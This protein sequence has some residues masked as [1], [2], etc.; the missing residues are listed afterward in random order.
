MVTGDDNSNLYSL[1]IETTGLSAHADEITVMAITNGTESRIFRGSSA[2]ADLDTFIQERPNLKLT[3]HNLKFDLRFLI[4]KKPELSYLVDRWQHDSSLL[5]FTHQDKIPEGWLAA[6]EVNR[7]ILNKHRRGNPHRK[8]GPHSLKTTAP[9]YLG[10]EAFW[11]AENHDDDAYVMKDAEY[12]LQLTRYFLEKLPAASVDFYT[13]FYMPWTKNLLA[14]EMTGI[15]LDVAKLA[16]MTVDYET[17]RA[18][19]E[20]ELEELW[21]PHFKAW[22]ELKRAE[23]RERYAEMCA[24]ACSRP[25]ANVDKTQARYSELEA[26]ALSKLEPLNLASTQQL[27]WLLRAR[28]GLNPIDL[29]GNPSTD[30]EALE[31]LGESSPDVK[32]LIEMRQVTKIATAFLP[33][34]ASVHVN[35][36]IHCT[37]NVT[38][39]RTGRLSCSDVNLQQVPGEMH[40]LFVADEGKKLIVF[41]LAAIEPTVLAYYSEDPQLCELML[42]MGDFHSTNAKAMFGLECAVSEVKK[43]Y[44]KYRG[45]AKTVGLAVLY[46]AGGNQ[47]YRTLMKEGL[48][49][50]NQSDAKAIVYRIRDLYAGVWKF[51]GALDKELEKGSVIYNLLGRPLKIQDKDNCYMHGLNTLVQSSASDLLQ[52]AALRIKNELG[53]QPLLLVHD[54]IV[55]QAPVSEVDGLAVKVKEIMTS[56]QLPT[57]FGNVPVRVEGKI[58]NEWEK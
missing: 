1:D 5:A 42:N 29:D 3:G 45:V 43:L 26:K 9:F 21:A 56:F 22:M 39:A 35:E 50:F 34:Y 12:S 33:E 11:E 46:G 25:N 38:T 49:S 52:H 2:L 4:T 55:L 27:T 8:A 32:R 47:V 6:Y 37:F 51:K 15:R 48:H 28:L 24:K 23:V 14:A 53:L 41:D 16:E 20:R 57:K 10:V 40:K 44:P 18:K 30:K 13:N 31:M 58:S 36:R 19:L 7:G 17:R 54:E